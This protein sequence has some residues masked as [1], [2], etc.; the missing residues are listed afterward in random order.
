MNALASLHWLGPE[1]LTLLYDPNGPLRSQTVDLLVVPSLLLDLDLER[2]FL[3]KLIVRAQSGETESFLV[4]HDALRIFLHSSV[5][6]SC[7]FM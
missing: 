4:L 7:V 2:F 1:N 3:A 5:F 6:F